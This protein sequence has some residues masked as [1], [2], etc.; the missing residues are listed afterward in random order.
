MGFSGDGA[1]VRA[2]GYKDCIAPFVCACVCVIMHANTLFT[3]S[4]ALLIH[5]LSIVI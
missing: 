3:E 1:L 2:C 5:S 4:I